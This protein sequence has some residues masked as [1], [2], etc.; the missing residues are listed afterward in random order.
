MKRK[1]CTLSIIWFILLCFVQPITKAQDHS[2]GRAPIQS[3]RPIKRLGA[4]TE[5]D[6]V[7]FGSDGISGA[8]Y[9]VG[10]PGGALS[11]LGGPTGFHQGG[12]FDG[13]GTF[14]STLSPSTLI[15]VDAAT[16]V[17]SIV[18]PITGVTGGQTITSMAWCEALGT[19][20]IG[21]TDTTTSELYS[22]DL[23]TGVATLIGSGT[24]GQKGLIA[25]ACDCDGNLYSVDIVT[26]DIWSVDPFTGIG[27]VIGPAGFDLNFA[28]D[29]DFNPADTTMYLAAFNNT[30]GSGQ[31]R[32]VDLATGS[33]TLLTDWGSV[34]LTDFG[35]E[36]GC[37]SN[38][39]VGQSSNPDPASRTTNVDVNVGSLKWTNGPGVTSIDV[40][41]DGS[42]VYSGAP[43]TTYILPTLDFSTTYAWRVDGS[44][45]S[46]TTFGPSWSFTTVDDTNIVCV[47]MDDF[48]AGLGNWVI[49]N[50]G[51]TC[52]W[53]QY[54]SP[55]PNTYTISLSTG[56]LLGADSDACGEGGSLLSTATMATPVDL[57]PYQSVWVEFDNDWNV[58]DIND[59][60][61]L[62]ISTDGGGTWMSVF[63]WIGDPFRDTHEV[64]DV[65]SV[66]GLQDSVLF[67]LRTIQPDWDWWWVIDNFGIYGADIIPVE[68]TSFGATVNLNEVLLSWSTT[69]E[70]NNIG[71]EV[72]RSNDG[73]DYIN[74]AF[75]E[76]KG[77][78]TETKNYTFIEKNLEVGSYKYRLK[79]ID[80]DGKSE[81]SNVV[82]VEIT[83][84]DKYTLEQNYPNPFNPSTKIKFSLAADSRVTLKVFDILGQEVVTLINGRLSAGSHDVDF[85]AASLNSGVYFYRIDATG[86][87]GANFTSVK[88]MILTK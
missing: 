10:I 84:P 43:D 4:I 64:W 65:S 72:Q 73:I 37:V 31:F 51:G 17:E 7:G 80:F 79:Q 46:C 27:T 56:C 9:S 61:H 12:D 55:F 67:R 82:E 74:I 49:T 88:K 20:F 54:C 50:D 53:L 70:T 25:I 22:L 71:F 62:E 41:F 14:Y 18:N 33:T 48:E 87:N 57:S 23:I 11:L 42:L 66:A 86:V 8:W 28:Q 77:T 2:L 60:A 69:T 78:I 83:A 29:A 5:G 6:D 58:V 21:T 30:T 38:C 68:L 44:N 36:V 59:E 15:T 52:D 24:I 63:A 40:W 3:E 75:V 39:P 34:Q 45:D 35:I 81:F 32:S 16:G 47:F 1:L 19:M 13:T 85:K 76:A 26:N